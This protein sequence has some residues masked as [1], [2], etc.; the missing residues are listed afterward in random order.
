MKTLHSSRV[1]GTVAAAAALAFSIPANAA[2][3]AFGIR[4]APTINVGPTQTEFLIVSGGQKAGFGSSDIDGATLGDIASL[5]IVRLD[6]RTRFTAGTGPY[7]APYL[8]FWITDGVNYA[9]VANE[10]SD[11]NFQPLYSNGYSLSFADLADKAAKIYENAD[12]S[13]LPNNG[14][15]LTFADLA[16]FTIKPPTI[17]ELTLGWSG[18]GTGAPREDGTNVAYGVNWVFGDTLANYVSG[19]PGYIV[20][21]DASVSVVPVPA[22]VW[23]FGS[24]L[25]LMQVVRRKGGAP[26]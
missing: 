12:K 11:G 25:G 20:G 21:N 22:A 18:L 26:A 13:W 5:D 15:G 4:N 3:T 10:P 17:A 14:V 9:V 6:D 23:L 19:D 2:F 8:N 24:A 1:L 16:G 7:V